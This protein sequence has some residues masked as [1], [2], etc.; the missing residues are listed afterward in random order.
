MYRLAKKSGISQSNFS[1][2][3]AGKLKE[4]SWMNMCKLADA[5]EVSL[6]EF[7][8][9]MQKLKKLKNHEASLQN[10]TFNLLDRY[11]NTPKI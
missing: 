8:I 1:N 7:R 9:E 4:A 3:K 2:L 5:L 11:L 6:N 10:V